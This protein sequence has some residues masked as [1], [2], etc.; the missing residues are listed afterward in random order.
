MEFTINDQNYRSIKLDA[1]K[2][3]HLSRRLVPV[4][5]ALATLASADSADFNAVVGPLSSA[6]ASMPDADCD[7][8]LKTCMAAVSIQQGNVWSPVMRDGVVMFEQID[9]KVLLQIAAKVIQDNLAGFF[10]GVAG[11]PTST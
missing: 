8:I 6:I 3:F 5:G 11:A 10:Q 2:Q 7:Y 9:L 4:I 1:F